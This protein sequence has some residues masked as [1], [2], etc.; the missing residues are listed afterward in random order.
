[1][2]NSSTATGCTL[3]PSAST[4][5]IARPGMRTSKIDIDEPLMKRSR[6]RSPG[7]NSAVQLARGEWPLTR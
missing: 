1:M 4:T 7:R 5:L 6:T 3:F 2:R